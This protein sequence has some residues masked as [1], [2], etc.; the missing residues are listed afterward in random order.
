MTANQ[1]GPLLAVRDLT[2]GYRSHSG[3]RQALRHVS[4]S[5]EHG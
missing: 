3:F 5:I 4:L 2:V 1:A